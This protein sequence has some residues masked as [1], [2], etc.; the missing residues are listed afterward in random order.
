M[1]NLNLA[2]NELRDDLQMR[3]Q[4]SKE[5]RH[6]YPACTRTSERIYWGISEHGSLGLRTERGPIR[7]ENISAA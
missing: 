6:L 5:D 3:R 7:T 2:R 4:N 1:S